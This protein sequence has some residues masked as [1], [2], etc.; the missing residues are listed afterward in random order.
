MD[1]LQPYASRYLAARVEPLII[2]AETRN[3]EIVTYD[4]PNLAGILSYAVMTEATGELVFE[5][6]TI[7]HVPLPVMRLWSS[8]DGLPLW[9]AST[10][11]PFE[12]SIESSVVFHQRFLDSTRTGR[13]M[14]KRIPKPV[15]LAWEWKA[16][17]FGNKAEIERLLS[18]IDGIGKH[19][20]DGMGRV[21]RWTVESDVFMPL[22]TIVCDDALVAPFPL[23]MLEH[24]DFTLTGSP[25]LVGW[26]P[27]L[28][29]RRLFN[30]GWRVG[31][32]VRQRE[33][34]YFGAVL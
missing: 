25:S 22:D 19:R 10:F 15:T 34:D 23:M 4:F 17:C 3:S 28:W 18:T 8:P 12:G 31:T 7:Y 1:E 9:A 5:D 13:F 6:E 20:H 2:T 11:F 16:R 26:T 33:I 24:V 30:Y 32:Q 29:K 21:Y 14:D 27:P